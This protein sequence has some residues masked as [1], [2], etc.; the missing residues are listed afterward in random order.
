MR[1][2]IEDGSLTAGHARALVAT[3]EPQTLADRIIKLGLTVREAEGLARG[4]DA[5]TKAAV[6]ALKDANTLALEKQLGETLGLKV[7]VKSKG[8]AGGQLV[9]RYKTLEQLDEVCAKLGLRD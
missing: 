1:K 2:L 9:I 4:E 5:K 6:K 8:R 3:D 7:E